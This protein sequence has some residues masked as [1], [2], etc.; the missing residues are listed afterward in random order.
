MSFDGRLQQSV[1]AEL[2][3]EPASRAGHIGGKSVLGGT[4]HSLCGRQ[5]AG[6]TAW[7]S[8]RAAAV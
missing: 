2:K 5:V 4:V 7:A 1:L 6:R 3:W 8:P